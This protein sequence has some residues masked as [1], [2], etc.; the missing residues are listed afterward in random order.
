[1]ES[2]SAQNPLNERKWGFFANWPE[3]STIAAWNTG[4]FGLFF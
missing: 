3:P 4:E 1:M 2:H